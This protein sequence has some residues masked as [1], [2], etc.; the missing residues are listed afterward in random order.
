MLH[1]DRSCS[2]LKEGLLTADPVAYL[3]VYN[4]TIGL[5]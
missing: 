4:L 2:L 1:V 3:I 5:A